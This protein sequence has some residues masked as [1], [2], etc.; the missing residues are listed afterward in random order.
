MRVRVDDARVLPSLIRFL[1]RRVDLV[2]FRA[3]ATEIDVSVLGSFKD[4]GRAELESHLERWRRR[5][6]SASAELVSDVDTPLQLVRSSSTIP[7]RTPS[8]HSP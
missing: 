8:T 5:H 6:S 2:T 1:E 3:G 4:G 7:K